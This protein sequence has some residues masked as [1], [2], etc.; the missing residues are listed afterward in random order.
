MNP[1]IKKKI[2]SVANQS[3]IGRRLGK[4]PQ[5]VNLWF[6]NEVP[7]S[8]VLSLCSCVDWVVTPH[9][10]R[11]DIYPNQRDGLPDLTAA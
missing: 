5:T 8:E 10:L 1:E 3:E 7:P 2:L 4:K 6:K 9:E 11:P